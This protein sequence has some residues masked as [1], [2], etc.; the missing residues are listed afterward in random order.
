M[1][2]AIYLSS[3]RTHFLEGSILK[4]GG[5]KQVLSSRTWFEDKSFYVF[6][7]FGGVHP[8]VIRPDSW[9]CAQWTTWPGSG[10]QKG[11]VQGQCPFCSNPGDRSGNPYKSWSQKGTPWHSRRKPRFGA[12]FAWSPWKPTEAWREKCKG[13][14]A[15]WHQ[16]TSQWM[17]PQVLI[18]GVLY[19]IPGTANLRTRYLQILMCGSTQLPQMSPRQLLSLRRGLFS[20]WGGSK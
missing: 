14:G 19:S 18:L 15:T 13:P 7:F 11:H 10:N 3:P 12:C 8:V 6:I 16:E 20:G 5:S 4:G 9:F 1:F 17:E 2:H